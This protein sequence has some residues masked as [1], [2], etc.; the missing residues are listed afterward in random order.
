[1]EGNAIALGMFD[2]VHIGH[3]AVIKGV[4]D[5]SCRSAV[6]TFD[7]IP[8]KT[9]G[10]ILSD[11]EKIKKLLAT[12]VDAVEVLNFDDVKDMTP[13]EFL[14]MLTRDRRVRKIACGFNFRFGKNAEGDTEFIRLYCEKNGIEFF[15]ADEVCVDSVTVSTSYIKKLLLEGKVEK[16]SKLLGKP[17]GFTAAVTKGDGRGKTL[18][19]PTINQIYPESKAPLKSG[20]YHTKVTVDMKVFDAVTDVGTRPTFERN[21][22]CA[23]SH[24]IGFNENC[25]GKNIHVSFLERIRDE[26]KFASVDE[27]VMEIGRNVEYVKNKT[28]K[29]V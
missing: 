27:L 29:G 15:M 6:I 2:S 26:K 7:K 1:M 18:G 13:E 21:I 28:S 4:L 25:Y 14:N 5:A 19:F 23:E 9:G 11:D 10:A 24:I 22:V 3:E 20:V 17:F 12:G 8:H 16:A